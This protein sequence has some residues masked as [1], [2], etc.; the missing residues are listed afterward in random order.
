VALNADDAG[1]VAARQRSGC[2]TVSVVRFDVGGADL[3]KA[4]DC[5]PGSRPEPGRTAVS[6][7][8]PQTWVWN[9]EQTA[10]RRTGG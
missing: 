9:G 8:G 6:V 1:F 7:A 10:V 3:R 5:L 2:R 4:G